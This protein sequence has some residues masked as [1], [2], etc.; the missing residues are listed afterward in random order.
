MKK[1]KLLK[2]VKITGG[3]IVV[4]FFVLFIWANWNAPTPADKLKPKIFALYNLENVKN[5][6]AFSQLDTRLKQTSGI[7]ATCMKPADKIVSVVFYPDVIN[8]TDIMNKLS[9]WSNAPVSI[10]TIVATGPTCPVAGIM[11]DISAI[12][13]LLCVRN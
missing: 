1:N 2:A 9:Q 7:L 12:K 10:K 4:L 13:R 8:T 3:T 5:P 11:G 6:D